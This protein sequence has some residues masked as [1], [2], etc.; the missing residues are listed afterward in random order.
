MLNNIY[1]YVYN[2]Y[3]YKYNIKNAVLKN[4]VSTQKSNIY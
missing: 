4:P 1:K 2:K 3:N